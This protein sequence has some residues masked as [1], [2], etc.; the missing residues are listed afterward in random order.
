ML[1]LTHGAAMTAFDIFYFFLMGGL[2]IYT[3]VIF[4]IFFVLFLQPTFH[5]FV[6]ACLKFASLELVISTRKKTE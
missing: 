4:Y 1:S 2:M 6:E 5:R 3:A